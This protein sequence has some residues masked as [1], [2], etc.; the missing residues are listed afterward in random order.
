VVSVPRTVFELSRRRIV[1]DALRFGLALS[2]TLVLQAV[3]FG[4]APDAKALVTALSKRFEEIIPCASAQGL[5][6]GQIEENRKALERLS[7]LHGT[8]TG[9]ALSCNMGDSG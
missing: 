4:L 6:D 7:M 2:N 9:P 1:A 3:R 8:S 5:N